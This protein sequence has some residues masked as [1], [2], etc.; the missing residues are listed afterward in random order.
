[1]N[2]IIEL[3]TTVQFGQTIDDLRLRQWFPN[4][5]DPLPKSR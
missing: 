5:F 3:S 1:V 4:L 2:Q